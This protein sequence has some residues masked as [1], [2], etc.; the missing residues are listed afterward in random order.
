LK[1][2]V[3]LAEMCTGSPVFGIP[4]LARLAH[5]DLEAAEAPDLDPLAIAQRRRHRIEDRVDHDLRVLLRDVR[6]LLGDRLDQSTLGHDY[7][8]PSDPECLR[9]PGE[10]LGEEVAQR[11]R[12]PRRLLGRQLLERLALLAIGER[13]DRQRDLL[14]DRVDA[15]DQRRHLLPGWTTSAGLSTRSAESSLL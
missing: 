15:R 13:A 12:L 6:R 2:G 7:S 1:N 9:L 4:A 14:L 3:R 11:R 5:L 8:P 10:F